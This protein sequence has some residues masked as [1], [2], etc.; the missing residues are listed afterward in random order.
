VA[1]SRLPSE[2]GSDKNVLWKVTIPGSGW[3]SPI[4]WGDKVFVTTAIT[5]SPAPPAGGRPGGGGKQGGGKQGGRGAAPDAVYRWEVHCLDRTTGKPLWKQLAHESKPRVLMT[6]PANTLASETPV[7][8]GERLFAYFGAVGLFCYDLDG[9]PLWKKDL[10]AFRMR[11]NWG[12]ASSPVLD[13]GRLFI[14]CD[15][16]EK[17]FLVALDAKTGDELWRVSRDEPTT[18]GT[19]LIW[20][21]KVRTELVTTGIRKI[22][23]YDPVSGKLLWELGGIGSGRSQCRASPVGDE[24]MLYA[25]IGGPPGGDPLFAVRAG[26]TGDITL[27]NGETSNTG[28]AWVSARGGPAMASP[29]VYRGYVYVVEPQNGDLMSCYDAKTGQ[30][31]YSRVRLGSGSITASPWAYDGKVFF[32]DQRGQTVV[33]RAGPQFEV[34]GKNAL[35]SETTWASPALAGGALFVRGTGHLYC[36]Q[37]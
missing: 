1:G 5:D 26:A 19:P 25:G 28:V 20:R 21:N 24:E 31:A 22:R 9:K 23:S 17:S 33:V 32:L 37:Q 2:W 30:P 8:D 16:E 34:V 35:S 4:V 36:I 10:G 6:Q 11:D 18:W 29:L 7:T 27:K 12:T 14:L 13:A 3:S 15:N